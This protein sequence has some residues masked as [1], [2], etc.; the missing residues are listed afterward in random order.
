[1]NARSAKMLV[2]TLLTMLAAAIAALG[3]TLD[4]DDAVGL[5]SPDVSAHG[6]AAEACCSK[7]SQG[8]PLTS[9][10]KASR[11]PA[12]AK[13]HIVLEGARLRSPSRG[14]VAASTSGLSWTPDWYMGVRWRAGERSRSSQTH[15]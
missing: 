14:S 1:M 3:V 10:I 11:C 6:S 4:D 12:C 9:T 13:L 5:Q 8:T 15:S 7:A 2:I